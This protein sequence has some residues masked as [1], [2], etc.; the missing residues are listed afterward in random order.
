MAKNRSIRISFSAD[1][2]Q[3]IYG[4]LGGEIG[5]LRDK[6]AITDRRPSEISREVADLTYVQDRISTTLRD[7]EQPEEP[8][9]AGNGQ[10]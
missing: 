5:R 8:T 1:E 2:L 9:L 6:A 10:P 4:L 7:Y 3:T